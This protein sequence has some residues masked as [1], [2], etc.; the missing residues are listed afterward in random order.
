MLFYLDNLFHISDR[1]VPFLEQFDKFWV[2][3]NE[4]IDNYP[5]SK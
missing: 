3:Q 4:Q 1:K 2:C 5:I